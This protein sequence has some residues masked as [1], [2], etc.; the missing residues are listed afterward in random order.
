MSVDRKW[1]HV[2]SPRPGALL[3]LFC[4]HYAGGAAQMFKTWQ[5]KIGSDI[6]VCA[7]QMPGRWSRIR[8]A[9]L[10]SVAQMANA[11]AEVI[12]PL[13]DRSYAIFG[14]SLG[15]AV[16]F[17]LIHALAEKGARPP[18]RLFVSA[19]N[20]PHRPGSIQPFHPL[21]D[22]QFI[23]ALQDNYAALP[24][25]VLEDPD[26]GPIFLNVLRADL[27]AIE[28]HRYTPRALF[29]VPITAMGGRRD[30]VISEA[31]LE[32]WGELTTGD[33]TLRMFDGDHFYIV[34]REDEAIGLIRK[35]LEAPSGR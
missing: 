31:Q 8:E 26:L 27:E 1:F 15:A 34:P 24:R 33:H 6:E 12:S 20:A 5:Q 9:P 29:S 32:A 17:E 3:R 4:F 21:P 25:E 7:V 11:V 22:A 18:V 35:T 19:R 23:E 30:Q 10:R 2:T 13:L 14:H 28:T 16:G